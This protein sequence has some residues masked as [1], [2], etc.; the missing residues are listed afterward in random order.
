MHLFIN[1]NSVQ[2]WFELQNK[3]M[4]LYLT[5]KLRIY[6]W[7]KKARKPA[8]KEK[9][10]PAKLRK[11]SLHEIPELSKAENIYIW[12]ES[13]DGKPDN[14]RCDCFEPDLAHYACV[15]VTVLDF[16]KKINV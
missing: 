12:L 2:L 8:M 13:N 1:Q 16:M 7:P 15:D 10:K 14:Y 6:C 5:S 9:H 4:C 3:V 11:K